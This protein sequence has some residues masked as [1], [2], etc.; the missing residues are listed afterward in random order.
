MYAGQPVYAAAPFASFEHPMESTE[1]DAEDL[2]MGEIIFGSKAGREGATT[3][4]KSEQQEQFTYTASSAAFAPPHYQYMQ[5]QP[6]PLPHYAPAPERAAPVEAPTAAPPAPAAEAVEA[7]AP[8]AAPAQASVSQKVP[9][10][11]PRSKP[12]RTEFHTYG[13]ANTH[14]TV[15]RTPHERQRDRRGAC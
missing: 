13:R 15:S 1:D 3:A 2:S 10:S 5:W 4:W 9:A 11:K 6:V 7:P 14:P 12:R 8:A